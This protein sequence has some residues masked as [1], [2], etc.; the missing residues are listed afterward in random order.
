MYLSEL[1]TCNNE[2]FVLNCYHLILGREPDEEGFLHHITVLQAGRSRLRIVRGIAR[3][4]E[5][6][7]RGVRVQGLRGALL[8]DWLARKSRLGP[9]LRRIAWIRDADETLKR[10]WILEERCGQLLELAAEDAAAG[11]Q[12]ARRSQVEMNEA[13]GWLSPRGLEIF[14]ELRG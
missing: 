3:S 12:R 9:W 6:R 11:K 13:A 8:W 7:R 1:L 14:E 2:Q 4:S 5:A 10:V